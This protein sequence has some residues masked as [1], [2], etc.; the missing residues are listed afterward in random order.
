[1]IA[2]LREIP[3]EVLILA[4]VAS[5]AVAV[6]GVLTWRRLTGTA[7]PHSEEDGL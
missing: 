5:F 2:Q 3:S 1:M 4:A 7:R 6:F